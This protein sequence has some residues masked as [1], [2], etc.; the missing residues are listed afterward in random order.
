MIVMVNL[1]IST[2]ADY[3]TYYAALMGG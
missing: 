2:L 3:L 1:M